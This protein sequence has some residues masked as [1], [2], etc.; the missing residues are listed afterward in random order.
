MCQYGKIIYKHIVNSN[1]THIKDEVEVEDYIPMDHSFP[2][3]LQPPNL[4]PPTNH[5]YHH[6]PSPASHPP[7]YHQTTHTHTPQHESH[8]ARQDSPYLPKLSTVCP[9][10]GN[11]SI[12]NGNPLKKMLAVEKPAAPPN[13]PKDKDTKEIMKK[14]RER[15]ICIV[16]DNISHPSSVIFLFL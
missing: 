6:H 5:S 14:R 12:R 4:H 9:K 8:T 7:S 15:A 13:K 3:R 16:R 1:K 2:H 10:H 11:T